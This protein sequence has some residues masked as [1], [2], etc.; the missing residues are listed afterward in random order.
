MA[1]GR[2]GIAQASVSSSMA[3]VCSATDSFTKLAFVIALGTVHESITSLQQH[4][5]DRSGRT[6]R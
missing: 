1:A 6:G 2:G 3:A 5:M 4:Q